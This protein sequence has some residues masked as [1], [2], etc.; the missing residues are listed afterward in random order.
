MK[1]NVFKTEDEV[2]D[3]LAD[4][5]V[6]VAAKSIKHHGQFSVA[7]SGGNSPKKLYE[8]LASPKFRDKVEWK[9]V[10]FFFGDERYVPHTDPQSN[11]LMAKKAILEPLDLSYRQI[12]PV[13]TSVSPEEAAARYTNDINLYF[14]GFDARFDL[15][16]LGLGDNSHT[17]SLFPH[18]PVLHD[19]TAS[20]KEVFLDD[21]QVFRITMTA[22][23]INQAHHIAYL[24]Y[25]AGKAEAVHHVIEDK[26]D[27]EN[28]PAQLIKPTDGD[29]QWFLDT[30]A[31]SLLKN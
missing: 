8:L 13:N 17:A 21:Q 6:E 27:I 23:L 26:R 19:K 16:L 7:L 15:V 9:K 22:P 12:F 3:G 11:Y 5:F 18:T 1:I 24:V 20:V 31:A 29:L 28:Y 10:H 4:Y 30:S 25:G 2:L 14:A